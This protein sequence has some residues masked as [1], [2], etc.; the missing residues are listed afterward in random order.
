MKS[1]EREILE[2][3]YPS[4]VSFFDDS[5]VHVVIRPH[6]AGD[7]SNQLNEFTVEFVLAQDYPATSPAIKIIRSRG[8]PDTSLSKIVRDLKSSAKDALGE[9]SI[10]QLIEL[11]RDLC[12]ECNQTGKLA[13]YCAVRYLTFSRR[14]LNLL[15]GL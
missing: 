9:C 12:T 3:M 14:V 13:L 15:V 1:E 5:T 11:G 2:I 8:V 10:V 6:T 7:E 4:E